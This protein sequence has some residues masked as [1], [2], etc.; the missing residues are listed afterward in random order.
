MNE[1]QAN[2]ELTY[3]LVPETPRCCNCEYYMWEFDNVK[4]I[5]RCTLSPNITP[6]PECGLCAEWKNGNLPQ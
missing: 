1:Q 5:Y 2:A 6:D 4:Y 3:H